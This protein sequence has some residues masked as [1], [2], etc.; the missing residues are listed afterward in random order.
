VKI[1]KRVT[2]NRG[3]QHDY[4]GHRITFNRVQRSVT[5][6]MKGFIDSLIQKHKISAVTSAPANSDLLKT[7]NSDAI[8]LSPEKH[9]DLHSTIAKLL[10]LA[11]HSRP[12]ILFP[13][14]H[15]TSRVKNLNTNDE[16]KVIQIIQYLAFSKEMDM[17]LHIPNTRNIHMKLFADASFGIHEK[18][19]SHSGGCLSIGKG[20]ICWKSKKQTLTTLSTAEAELVAVHEMSGMLFHMERFFVAQGCH[21]T[22]KT[23]YQDNKATIQMLKSPTPSTRNAHIGVKFFALSDHI[24]SKSIVMKHLDTNDMVADLLTKALTGPAFQKFAKIILGIAPP[25]LPH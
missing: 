19:R 12:D 7:A 24:A 25:S 6:S 16:R 8:P 10:Y 9:K 22:S 23:V 5:L 3:D 21:V 4:L 14:N 15:L 20:F 18:N 11:I 17:T 13:V 1:F 2:I